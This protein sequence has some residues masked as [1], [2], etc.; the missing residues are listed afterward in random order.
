MHESLPQCSARL[1]L[2]SR[3]PCSHL[4][5]LRHRYCQNLSAFLLGEALPERPYSFN[6]VDH[7][8]WDFTLTVTLKHQEK[9]Y[10]ALLDSRN[11]SGEAN[12]DRVAVDQ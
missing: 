1:T 12:I 6:Q 10:S 4:F 11:F 3:L 5:Q 8:Y 2:Q 7:G 9:A